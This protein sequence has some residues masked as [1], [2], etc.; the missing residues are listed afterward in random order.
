MFF[1]E[2]HCNRTKHPDAFKE[3]YCNT[4]KTSQC[5]FVIQQNIPLFSKKYNVIQQNI[6]LGLNVL[7]DNNHIGAILLKLLCNFIEAPKSR[8]RR[9]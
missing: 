4:N 2:S 1:K 7:R 8:P 9:R 3:I 6:L 5:F